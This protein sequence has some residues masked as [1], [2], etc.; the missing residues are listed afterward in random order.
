MQMLEVTPHSLKDSDFPV[1]LP[2]NNVPE[3]RIT[4][5]VLA[6]TG[7]SKEALGAQRFIQQVKRL[8]HKD[9]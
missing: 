4:L 3:Q 7:K 1:S 2:A 9:V 8:L 5:V 6:S